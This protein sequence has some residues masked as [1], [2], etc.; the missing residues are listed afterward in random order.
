MITR[1]LEVTL[2]TNIAMHYLGKPYKWGGDD[3][4]GFDC[5]GLMI[6]VLKSTGRLPR[7]GDWTAALL[8]KMLLPNQVD[9]P[10]EGCLV[11]WKTNGLQGSKIIHVEYCITKT[12]SV[13]ASGGGSSVKTDKDAWD[14][15]A[16]IKVRPIHS[17]AFIAGYIN[18]FQGEPEWI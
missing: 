15:N 18:P 10:H 4:S 6:E 1:P 5:S 13:G 2:A 8:Y 17:R 14:R 7:K 12:L 9:T 16:Y 3:P 11:F